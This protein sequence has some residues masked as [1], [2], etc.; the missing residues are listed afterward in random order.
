[1]ASILTPGEADIRRFPR[2]L[3]DRILIFRGPARD[4][5]TVGQIQDV[6]GWYDFVGDLYSAHL[7]VE[8]DRCKLTRIIQWDIN[9]GHLRDR[10]LMTPPAD[11][12]LPSLGKLPAGAS[13]SIRTVPADEIQLDTFCALLPGSL[14]SDPATTRDR[15]ASISPTT[16]I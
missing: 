15:S 12:N 9:Q 6:G 8:E 4:H 13:K 3:I 1:M 7:N 10:K 16:C 14:W 2:H 11:R 5:T